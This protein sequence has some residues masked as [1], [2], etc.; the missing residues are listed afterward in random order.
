VSIIKAVRDLTERLHTGAEGEKKGE[1]KR[2]GLSTAEAE[3]VAHD[4][5][6]EMRAAARDLEFEKAAALRDQLFELRGLIETE[7]VAR[8]K[9]EKYQRPRA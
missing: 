3:R 6:Q 5:D 8:G 1:E 4:L 9:K 7:K 2:L